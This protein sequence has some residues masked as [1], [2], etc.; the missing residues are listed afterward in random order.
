MTQSSSRKRTLSTVSSSSESSTESDWRQIAARRQQQLELL[1]PGGIRCISKR[2]SRQYMLRQDMIASVR[3]ATLTH[4]TVL[5]PLQQTPTVFDPSGLVDPIVSEVMR[6]P[7]IWSLAEVKVFLQQYA[8]HR[9]DFRYIANVM[10][11]KTEADCVDFYYRFKLSLDLMNYPEKVEAS[12]KLKLPDEL[13]NWVITSDILSL[14]K[15]LADS[16]GILNSEKFRDFSLRTI[17][18]HRFEKSLRESSTEYRRSS[19]FI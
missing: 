9:K 14:L 4:R 8:F 5:P 16:S 19:R 13:F 17:E 2:P 11:S 10:K 12:L 7:T 6:R 3:P 18:E 15:P 1:F